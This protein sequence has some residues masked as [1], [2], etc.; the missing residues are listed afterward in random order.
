MY[1]RTVC[2]CRLASGGRSARDVGKTLVV[3]GCEWKRAGKGRYSSKQQTLARP[4]G[5]TVCD[6]MARAMR[7][8]LLYEEQH[9]NEVIVMPACA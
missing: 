5:R 3:V 1:G 7:L 9:S 4:E 2:R 8:M 6:D